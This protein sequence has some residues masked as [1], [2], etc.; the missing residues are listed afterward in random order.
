MFS[1]DGAQEGVREFTS[2]FESLVFVTVL[3]S[4]FEAP[5][6]CVPFCVSLLSACS[7]WEG[8]VIL[9]LGTLTKI[10]AEVEEVVEFLEVLDVDESVEVVEIEEVA[11]IVGIV[12]FSFFDILAG[13]VRIPTRVY[14]HRGSIEIRRTSRIIGVI[15]AIRNIWCIRF[16]RLIGLLGLLGTLRV[17]EV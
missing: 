17:I 9:G 2:L 3:S 14:V 10:F 7:P 4:K 1:A 16:L 5:T 6:T 13:A 11:G 15:R 8:E 12:E